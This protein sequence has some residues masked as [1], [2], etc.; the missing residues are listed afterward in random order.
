MT[1]TPTA[2]A[3]SAPGTPGTP[4]APLDPE[5]LARSLRPFGYSTM[6]PAAAYTDQAVFDWVRRHVFAAGW[7]C[8][9]RE[10][11]LVTGPLTQQALTVGDVPV[12][13]TRADG[14]LRAFANTCRHRG[15]ELLGDGCTASGKA[16]TCPYHLWSYGL[17]GRLVAAPRMKDSPGFD[18]ADNPLLPVP[19][20]VWHGWVMVNATGTAVPLERYVGGMESL[21]APYRPEALRLGGR[22]T[23]TLAANY[24]VIAENYHE[25]YHCPSIHPELCVVTP[26]DSGDNWDLPGAWVGGS[27]DLKDFA[28]TMSLDGRSLGVNI[29][30]ADPRRVL[31]LGLF[32]NVLLSLHPDYVMTQRMVAL[33]PDRTWVECSWFFPQEAFEKEGFD[34]RYAVDF[35]DITNREDWSACESVQRGLASPHFRPGPLAPNE[36]AVHQWVAMLGRVYGGGTPY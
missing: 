6:L 27:M 22:H 33:A 36:D 32:P 16:V 9:G 30:G 15:H 20:E 8:L 14:V 12:L 24:K 19:L 17:D 25:C 31:Y 11:E 34:P 4:S 35:W 1:T 10:D 21:V 7:V 13:L 23:Y 26:P 5:D 28:D 3:T 18:P 2:P 29:D